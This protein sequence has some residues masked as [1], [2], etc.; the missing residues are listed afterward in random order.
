[1]KRGTN[2]YALVFFCIGVCLP[3]SIASKNSL[4][5]DIFKR[6]VQQE[7]RW[8]SLRS[9]VRVSVLEYDANQYQRLKQNRETSL[10]INLPTPEG[11]IKLD[12]VQN[13]ILTEDFIL[14]T[15]KEKNIPFKSG[16]HYKGHIDGQPN[17]L[18]AVSFFDD[19]VAAVVN[20]YD[21]KQ[22]VVG[23]SSAFRRGSFVVYDASK[24][25]GPNIE[26]NSEALPNYQERLNSIDSKV[27][28]QRSAAKCVRMYFE[29]GKSLYDS[30]GGTAGAANYI[31]SV[32]N[33]VSALYSREGINIV[34]SEIFVWTTT[35]P[36]NSS[37]TTSTLYGF[38]S[39]RKDNFNG[40]LAQFVRSKNSSSGLSGVAWLDVL[41]YSYF[42]LNQSGRFSTTEIQPT[43][44]SLPTYSW[45]V[46]VVTHEI[47]HNLGSPHTQSCTWTG[48]AIDNCA[49]TEGGCPKGP[50]PVNGGTIMSYCHLTSYGI[51]LS[52]GFG[53]KPGE[54][55][56]SRVSAA[57][58]LPECA[59][60]VLCSAPTGLS[61]TNIT[62]NS[63]TLNWA[64]SGASAYS[65]Q[66]KLSNATT[67]TTAT[68]STSGLSFNLSG[69]T[70]G[71]SYNWQVNSICSSS[72]STYTAGTFTTLSSNCLT[73]APSS[74]TAVNTSSSST[75]VSWSA[76][77]GATSYEVQYKR[78]A[79]STWSVAAAASTALSISISSLSSEISYDWRVRANCSGGAGPFAQS[80]FT[81]AAAAA[82]NAPSGLTVSNV[83]TSGATLS[84][85]AVSG[86]FNYSLEYKLTTSSSW[87]TMDPVQALSFNVSNLLAGT[88]YDWRVKT[89][90]SSGTSGYSQSSLTTSNPA[91]NAP[92]GL[93]ASN[94]TVNSATVNWSAVSGAVNY[95]LEYKLSTSSTWIAIAGTIVSTSYNLSGL[96]ASSNYDW[97]VKTNC[98]SG[99][100]GLTTSSFVLA[101]PVCSTPGSLVSSSITNNSA[102]VSWSAVSGAVGYT[103]E[104]KLNSS[105]TWTAVS[106]VLTTTSYTLTNLVASSSYNWQVKTNCAS[107]ASSFSSANF[108]TSAP[109]VCNAPTGLSASS[110]T[111]SSANISWSA[112]SGAVSYSIEYKSSLS[113]T[114]VAVP[115]L[116]S[117]TSITLNGLSASATYDWRVRTNCA[118]GTSGYGTSRF[119][120]SPSVALTCNSPGSLN[121]TG[122]TLTTAILNWG[123]VSGASN[124]SVE[125]KKS[126]AST[127][128]AIPG[129]MSSASYTLTGLTPGTLYN[130][131]VKT[132]C[133][134]GSSSMTQ[135]TFTTLADNVCP[136]SGDV[137]ENG[138]RTSAPSISLNTNVLGKIY[139]NGDN[140]YYKFVLASTSN[141]ACSLTNLPA[142]FDLRILNSAGTTVGLSQ[143]SG[144]VNEMITVSLA[145]GTYYVRIYGWG[146]SNH[147]SLCYTL[148]VQ[149]GASATSSPAAIYSSNEL[150]TTIF[151]NPVQADLNFDIYGLDA[152]ATVTIMDLQSRKLIQKETKENLNQIN[153]ANLAPGFYLLR[154]ED[155]NRRRTI[156]KFLKTQ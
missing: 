51:N 10:K 36:Y 139:P 150:I 144:L 131:Q 108:T 81:S 154:V 132:N 97:R 101:T 153:V 125:Y 9:N 123:T 60:I 94:I 55:I 73:S 137:V 126:T 72:S 124:Y 12:L 49:N 141:I 44:N 20:T 109:P 50:A 74:L 68:A 32:F 103:L 120:T 104:Y 112:V 76:V 149:T 29:L 155:E 100:S 39:A 116:V 75:T 77:S 48:G 47:G 83:T 122:I 52:N 18:V 66:Y 111:S 64:S 133:S 136:G 134:S 25:Q 8:N 110:I 15:D 45:T 79:N 88:N 27:L 96:T 93:T 40:N 63:V 90:C 1:M 91:C 31:S 119:T 143:K 23:N 89:N 14:N 24:V 107:N 85:S 82:C 42:P 135:S 84:W 130:W 128:T 56:R 30:Q 115:G 117:T 26:C 148:K 46:E 152:T 95:S 62:T 87:S 16:L 7:L 99:S 28:E 98:A 127:W 147:G 54:R 61:V 21:G 69:L 41:C 146:P 106:G 118:S 105:S 71:A 59:A 145:A 102:S 13:N 156:Q 6:D 70:T 43:F 121:T 113:A 35:E 11:D 142:D 151:P 86:A 2:I 58:C 33:Q 114:W 78:T 80:Q 138:V 34:I 22:F 140:D 4:P 3:K 37:S 129:T 65:V 53:P 5:I 67:W 19:E 38:G 57:T 92:G 17:S